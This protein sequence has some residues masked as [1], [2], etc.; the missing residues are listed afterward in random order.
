MK[1]HPVV[2][3]LLTLSISLSLRAQQVGQGAGEGGQPTPSTYKQEIERQIVL[4]EVAVGKSEASHAADVKLGRL[5]SQL[6]LLYEDV[7]LW[8][9]SE[10]AFERAVAL[11]RRDGTS[12]GELATAIADMGSMHNAIGKTRESEKEEQEALGIRKTLNDELQ[13]ARSWGDLA[14]LSVAEQKYERARDFAQQALTEF[15][16]DP[17]AQPFD[18]ITARYALGLAYCHL[19]EYAQAIPLL[20]KATEDAKSGKQSEVTLGF[21]EFLL[22]YAYW[23]SGDLTSANGHLEEGIARMKSQLGWGHPS[24]LNAL[25]YYAKFLRETRRVEMAEAA[26]REIRRAE[27]TVDIRAMEARTGMAGFNGLR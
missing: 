7:G 20:A 18:L 23:R 10:S 6:G 2:N 3:V 14:A 11:F 4:Y 16:A 8:G 9:R 22:G 15:S 25:G 21:G 5:Y 13:V 17:K 27:A 19:K 26:E 24:Y 12:N 1:I